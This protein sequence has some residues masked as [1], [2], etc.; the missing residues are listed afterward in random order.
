MKNKKLDDLAALSLLGEEIRKMVKKELEA[1]SFTTLTKG[2]ITAVEDGVYTVAL[3]G[4]SYRVPSKTAY[5]LNDTVHIL[6]PQ[7][8]PENMIIIQKA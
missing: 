3:Y 6:V 4:T 1:A 2:R 5:A 8:A 7:N